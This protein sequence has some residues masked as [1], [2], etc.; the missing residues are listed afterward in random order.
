[1][2]TTT[3]TTTGNTTKLL[4]SLMF[5]LAPLEANMRRVDMITRYM[6]QAAERVGRNFRQANFLSIDPQNLAMQERLVKLKN[7]EALTQQRIATAKL[8]EA[9]TNKVNLQVEIQRATIQQKYA[10]AGQMALRTKQMEADLQNKLAVAENRRLQIAMQRLKIEQQMRILAQ[11]Q[12]G[13]AGGTGGQ[14]YTILGGLEHRMG[15]FF[16][17]M[18]LFG[19]GAVL[20]GISKAMGDVEMGMIE[21]A[22]IQDDVTFNFEEMRQSL[23]DLGKEYGQ[24]WSVVHDIALRWSQAG[25]DTRD[26]LEATRASLLALNTAELDAQQS[27][28]S[29]IGIMSQWDLEVTDLQGVIDKIN[30]TADN[31]VVTSQDLVDGLLR[32]SGSARVL[33]MSLEET[34]AILT[35]MREASGRTGRE[36][37]NALNSILSFMQRNTALD[38]FEKMGINVWADETKTQFRNLIEIFDQVAVGWGT[39]GDE[40]KDGFVQAANEAGLFTEEMA[41]V[42]GAQEE[43]DDLQKRDVSQAMAGIYRR[44][45]L[46]ALLQNWST[47]QEVLNGLVDAQGYSLRENERTMEAYQK[48]V[49]ALRMAITEL[50]V[51]I[52]DAGLLDTMKG[53]VDGT[54]EGV[55]AFRELP[56]P[57]QESIIALLGISAALMG[58]NL[59]FRVF[60]GMGIGGMLIN[61][62]A[63]IAGVTASTLG[64]SAALN[65]LAKNPMVLVIGGIAALT[66]A[67]IA[68]NSH[69]AKAVENAKEAA[70]D[71]I[72]HSNNISN[73]AKR[74]EE[75][76]EKV[77]LNESEQTELQNTMNALAEIFPGIV[78]Q[79]DAQGNAILFN[80]DALRDNIALAK[81]AAAANARD[82]YVKAMDKK[83]SIEKKIN[84][85]KSVEDAMTAPGAIPTDLK[86]AP[87]PIINPK[88]MAKLRDELDAAKRDIETGLGLVNQTYIGDYAWYGDSGKG[89]GGGSANN[90]KTNN[91]TP[92]P[93]TPNTATPNVGALDFLNNLEIQA[94]RAGQ[95]L[96][97]NKLM[98]N[99]LTNAIGDGIPTTQQMA[100]VTQNYNGQIELLTQHQSILAKENT[101]LT[102]K[103]NS[104]GD[105]TGE[106]TNK[107]LDNKN[108][109]LQDQLQ[110][111]SLRKEMADFQSTIDNINFDQANAALQHWTSMGVYSVE[112]QIAALHR[113]ATVKKLTTEEQRQLDMQSFNLYKKL[114]GDQVS[115]VQKAYQS[116]LNIIEDHYRDRLKTIED[117]ADAEIAIIQRRIDALDEEDNLNDREEARTEHDEKIKSLIEEQQYHELRTGIEHEKSLADIKKQID[118]ENRRW[119]AQQQD[120][121]RE[122]EKRN[123]QEQIDDIKDANDEKKQELEDYYNDAKAELEDYYNDAMDVM[124]DATQDMLAGLAATDGAWFEQGKKWIEKL[125]Q[126]MEDGGVNLPGGFDDF[127]DDVKDESS[128]LPTN[129]SEKDDDNKG[130]SPGGATSGW[131]IFTNSS[132]FKYKVSPDGNI[133]KNINDGRGDVY[134]PASNYKYLE[135]DPAGIKALAAAKAVKSYD[136]GGSI[137]YDQIAQLHANEYVLNARTVDKLGGMDNVEKLVAKVQNPNWDAPNMSTGGMY[138]GGMVLFDRA[139]DRIVAAIEGRMGISF[140]KLVNIEH[141]GFEDEADMEI[142]NRSLAR[143]VRT[144]SV[145]RG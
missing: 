48:R 65:I 5:N 129:D 32:S 15:W 33:G 105:I 107:L 108:A 97:Y 28:V 99:L 17:S 6:S 7:T 83:S 122:D 38:T 82:F 138:S 139:A 40:L 24:Q 69:Q 75:L 37:G 61:L 96:E 87:L 31:F 76:S 101:L 104:T 59:I 35:A 89:S 141:V 144:L 128:K 103:I 80:N 95:A 3:G 51:A 12:Q 119:E 142:F 120:W 54:R 57:V 73:L 92:K 131:Q 20:S 52:G 53:L 4:G 71:A 124:N 42:V 133:F 132:G 27:T 137:L 62:A 112:Q 30:I 8:K 130:S 116:R 46:L 63:R 136:I 110:I 93:T 98:L 123:L 23:I 94:Q 121:Q 11:Q 21:I 143:N 88:E 22:R 58:V 135:N 18:M 14:D 79:W 115:Q 134:V 84:S 74:Y 47:V 19:S 9:Q 36:V 86:A 50:A 45:Y 67:V 77:N 16:S 140:D 66:A 43:W 13:G 34:I 78:A 106:L 29:L 41:G 26:T 72:T 68:Y 125:I 100:N 49:E 64:L 114:I 117:E 81:E 25:L 55:E 1:M 10:Q 145:G 111:G 118:E 2:P 126:G 44:N 39:M 91:T 56:Q 70:S 109:I 85:L 60:L 102:A 127:W 90:S 113:L